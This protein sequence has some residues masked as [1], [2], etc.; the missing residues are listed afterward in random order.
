MIALFFILYRLTCLDAIEA[1][2]AAAASR[3]D[4]LAY[5]Q[6]NISFSTCLIKLKVQN[7]INAKQLADQ[8]HSRY[9][10]RSI[11]GKKVILRKLS[12]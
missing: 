1:E 10:V 6:S 7:A 11:A 4:E 8:V 5:E 9:E 3:Q 12:R 2:I